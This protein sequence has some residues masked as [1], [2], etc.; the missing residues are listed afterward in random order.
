MIQAGEFDL[1][2]SCSVVRTV[3]KTLSMEKNT[4]LRLKCLK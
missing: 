3:L 1:C 2:P 4:F